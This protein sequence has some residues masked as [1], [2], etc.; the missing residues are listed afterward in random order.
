ML[1]AAPENPYIY[2]DLLLCDFANISRSTA[3]FMLGTT[4]S[5]VPNQR[6]TV[7]T[8][9]GKILFLKSD[10]LVGAQVWR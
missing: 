1:D 4:Q 5:A 8:P 2:S 7:Q 10:R 3:V 6:V 9:R